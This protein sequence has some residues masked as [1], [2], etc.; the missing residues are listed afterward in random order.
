MGWAR[1]DAEQARVQCSVVAPVDWSAGRTA[2]RVGLRL[3]AAWLDRSVRAAG[4][5]QAARA[6]AGVAFVRA[7]QPQ[8]QPQ[9]PA[10]RP[11]EKKEIAS[12]KSD[13]A[14]EREPNAL[15]ALTKHPVAPV[16][17]GVLFSR[18]ISPTSRSR[19]PFRSICPSGGQA[20]ADDLRPEPA[21]LRATHGDVRDARH[22]AARIRVGADAARGAAA[23]ACGVMTGRLPTIVNSSSTLR[24]ETE[25]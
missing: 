9:P 6:Q 10:P 4:D 11:P 2:Q 3:A 25:E 8:P 12:E 21:A 17:G 16:V 20:V 1:V 7:T 14:Q 5:A 18:R 23:P 19:P 22:D 24:N 15:E 13:S